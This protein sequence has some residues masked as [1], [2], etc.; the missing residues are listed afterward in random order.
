MLARIVGGGAFTDE[1]WATLVGIEKN[2]GEPSVVELPPGGVYDSCRSYPPVPCPYMMKKGRESPA[3]M[4][5][6]VLP[7]MTPCEPDKL[8]AA[9]DMSSDVTAPNAFGPIHRYDASSEPIVIW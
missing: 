8:I 5:K 3:I 4:F 9:F 7:K 1:I 6:L 2:T